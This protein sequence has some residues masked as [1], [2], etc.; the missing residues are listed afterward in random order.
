MLSTYPA[1]NFCFS[2]TLVPIARSRPRAMMAMRSPSTSASS[3][4]CVV[5]TMARPALASL[6]MSHT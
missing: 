4:E 2:R 1:P 3:M 6:M 5:S